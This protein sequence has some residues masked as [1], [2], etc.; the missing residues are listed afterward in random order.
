MSNNSVVSNN[1]C[2]RENTHNMI[3]VLCNIRKGLRVCH[4]N[5]QSMIRKID[6]FRY[7]FEKS[8]IEIICV[9]ESWLTKTFSDVFI[10]LSGYKV[11]RAD[12]DSPGGGVAMFVRSNLKCSLKLKS[13]PNHRPEYVFTEVLL[14]TTKILVGSIYR[15]ANNMDMSEFLELFA[16][17]SSMYEHII[18]AGDLNSNAMVDNS[19]TNEFEALGLSLINRSVPTHFTSTTSTLLDHIYVSDRSRVLLYDQLIASNFSKHDLIFATFK[20]NISAEEIH[21][22]YYDYKNIDQSRLSAEIRNIDW[23]AIYTMTSVEH[24]VNFLSQN[25]TT[26]LDNCVPKKRCIKKATPQPWIDNDIKSLIAERDSIYKRWKRFR[27]ENLKENHKQIRKRIVREIKR[28]KKLY[29]ESKF[30]RISQGKDKWNEIRRVGLGKSTKELDRSLDVD[31]INRKFTSFNFPP[32]NNSQLNNLPIVT[33]S[34]SQFSFT[35]VSTLEVNYSLLSIKSNATGLDSLPPIFIK[36][37]LPLLLP[38]IVHIYNTI[39]TSS[40]FPSQWKKAKVFP[41]PKTNNDLRPVAILP[42]FSKGIEKI[43]QKQIN[44]YL[45]DHKLLFDRQSGFRSHRSCITALCDVSEEIRSALDKNEIAFL[46]LLDH[47]KAFDSLDPETFSKKLELLF[48]FSSSSCTLIRSYLTDRAQSVVVENKTSSLLPL[49]RGVPQGSIIGPLFFSLY[50]NDLPTVLTTCHIHMYADDVQLYSNC[51]HSKI[52]EEISKINVDLQHVKEWTSQNGLSV[53]PAKS[54]CLCISNSPLDVSTLPS[55]VFDNEPTE[56]VNKAKNLGVIF[57]NKLNFDDHVNA[58]AGKIYGILRPLRCAQ[59]YT[60]EHIRIL[61]AKAC[62]MP[63]LLY[64]CELFA[65]CSSE[66]K[67]KLRVAFNNLIRYVYKLGPFESVSSHATR[68]YGLNFDTLLNVRTLLFLHRVLTEK[69]PTYLF[70]KF[71]WLRSTRSR[72]LLVPNHNRSSSEKHFFLHSIDLWNKLPLTLR[73][74]QSWTHF[75][76]HLISAFSVS[77]H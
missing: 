21:Y 46:L 22:E 50:I 19:L 51:L 59:N 74:N 20:F 5:A 70:E 33:H 68:L 34:Y 71:Q 12:R 38:Y 7:L 77:Q 23:N 39:L 67:R 55:V 56:F 28:K 45:E 42:F 61:M 66:S 18:I 4:I 36:L 57:N 27:L 15:R 64:G 24:Q 54:K 8:G 72:Q 65:N 69:E 43:M 32:V 11:F 14:D 75:R 10:G 1:V 31:E 26:L 16:N 13:D 40:V 52:N 29:F 25:I 41:L 73:S 44:T 49:H 9:S 63:I 62:V 30:A 3:R 35:T 47:T 48:N 58:T 53:N 60:P 6:E 2:S 76:K 37:L 17:L